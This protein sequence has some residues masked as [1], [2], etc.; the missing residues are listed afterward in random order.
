M[1]LG[2]IEAGGT[3]FV[4]V[5]GTE[6]GEI[7]ER[8]KIPTTSPEET[9]KEVIEFFKNK[10]IESLGIASFGPVAVDPAHPNYG[11]ILKT[12]KLA[13]AD[14]P[15]LHILKEAL[16]CPVTIDTDVNAAA[17]AEAKKGNAWDVKSCLYLTI[18]TGVGGGFYNGQL[19]HGRLH[20]EM[21][22]MLMPIGTDGFKGTCPF[23]GSCLEGLV[24]GPAIEVRAGKK[25]ELIAKDDPVWDQVAETIAMGL[26]NYQMILSPERIILGGGVMH[27]CHLYPRIHKAFYRLINGYLPFT[28]DQ[29]KHHIV[30]PGL[31]DDTG[32]VGALM[33]ALER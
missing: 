16:N 21:G 10:K 29:V 8:K 11:S 23:H 4:C 9:L 6:K 26:V 22:H 14:T 2:G 25:A 32:S 27:Q 18:G 3:K 12:P 24:S 28:E 13:W 19:L 15:I 1:I 7:L 17:L 33:L 5:V 20:P 31:G 30:S